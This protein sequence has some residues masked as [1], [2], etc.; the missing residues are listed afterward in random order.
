[1]IKRSIPKSIDN[2]FKVLDI[3]VISKEKLIYKIKQKSIINNINKK[4]AIINSL[5]NCNKNIQL[6]LLKQFILKI[7]DID[8]AIISINIYYVICRSKRA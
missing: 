2:F 1:M 4:V 7:K 8:I 3:I 6:L 5:D